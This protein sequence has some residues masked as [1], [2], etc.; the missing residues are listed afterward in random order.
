MGNLSFRKAA[1]GA[2]AA[3]TDLGQCTVP[4][5]FNKA[6]T[7]HNGEPRCQA[8]LDE[9]AASD[10]RQRAGGCCTCGK[11]L[12]SGGEWVGNQ[13]VCCQQCRLN[14]TGTGPAIRRWEPDFSE[15]G[16][17]IQIGKKT[18][19]PDKPLGDCHAN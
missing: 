13:W 17:Q 12:E 8:S 4:G 15:L 18:D 9:I 6:T 3:D 16:K 11:V 1:R 2:D 7:L 14:L 5:C 10:R 19:F